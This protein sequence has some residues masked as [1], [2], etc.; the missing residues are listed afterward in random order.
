[1]LDG[2]HALAAK[3]IAELDTNPLTTFVA[4]LLQEEKKQAGSGYGSDNLFYD[5]QCKR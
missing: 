3:L 4:L 2:D 5:N 1:L